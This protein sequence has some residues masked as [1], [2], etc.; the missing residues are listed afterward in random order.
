MFRAP[1]LLGNSGE[2]DLNAY[3]IDA[4]VIP[5]E[6]VAEE[7]AAYSEISR[8]WSNKTNAYQMMITLISVTL[9][10]FGLGLTL[11]RWLKGL[12]TLMG[13]LS[14]S[15]IVIW[16]FLTVIRPVPVY[17]QESIDAYVEGYR[18]L[19]NTGNY[20]YWSVYDAVPGMAEKAI[21]SFN[22]AIE[23]RPTYAKAYS[24]RGD[25]CA[26]AGEALL[27]GNGDATKR[28]EL[29]GLAVSSYE[30]ANELK[31]DDYHTLWNL[32]WALYMLGDY[33]RSITEFEKGIELAPQAQLGMRLDIAANLL[34]M[35]KKEEG[36]KQVDEAI[37][38]A[39]EHPTS[40]DPYY[41]RQ[42]ARIIGRLKKVR[43]HDG[44][45]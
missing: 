14:L 43:P 30:K 4:V 31:P 9:F 11:E 29:L 35:G 40:S 5:Q 22:K 7:R 10:L 25:A 16:A 28:D 45:G 27:L 34:G 37:K 8:A 21:T 15:G 13:T 17:S 3:W 6:K 2:P 26:T 44:H 24:Y 38:I 32:G 39:S 1:Y 33:P 12:F 41:F 20:E 36:L 18:E 23:L 42:L 19:I